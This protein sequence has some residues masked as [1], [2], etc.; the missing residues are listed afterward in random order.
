MYVNKELN[1][2]RKLEKYDVYVW[3]GGIKGHNCINNLL[4]YGVNVRGCFDNNAS[5]HNSKICDGVT[6]YNPGIDGYEKL[7]N[8][9]AYIVICSSF[10]REISE[11]LLEE[12]ISNFVSFCKLDFGGGVEFYDKGYFE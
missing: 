12:G 9:K 10:E 11:Q 4:S 8:K 5:L 1:W 3:G 2:L 7:R 6:I